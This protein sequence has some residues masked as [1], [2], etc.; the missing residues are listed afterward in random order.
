M[1]YTSDDLAAVRK[2]KVDLVS[3]KR[4][5]QVTV[6]GRTIRYQESSLSE[7]QA[8]ETE[9]LSAINRRPRRIT[10]QTSKL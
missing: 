4:V 1:S 7:M 6:R 3:G 5:G 10:V 9:I 8:L 2:A